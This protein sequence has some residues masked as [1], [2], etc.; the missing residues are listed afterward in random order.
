MIL[1]LALA[2]CVCGVR[3]SARPPA[4]EVQLQKG[5]DTVQE[6]CHGDKVTVVVT[7]LSDTI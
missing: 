4:H 2:G 6:Q 1:D 3:P 7:V 5:P